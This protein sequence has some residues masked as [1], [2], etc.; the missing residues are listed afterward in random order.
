LEQKSQNFGEESLKK[1]NLE[2]LGV[3]ENTILKWIC[4]KLNGKV[5]TEFIYINI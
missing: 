2:D 5:W 3:D 4:R 1:G